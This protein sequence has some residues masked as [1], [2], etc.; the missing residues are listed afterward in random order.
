M[1][2]VALTLAALDEL[3]DALAVHQ[4]VRCA[5]LFGKDGLRQSLSREGAV[6]VALSGALP[7]DLNPGADVGVDVLV[8]GRN[9]NR[10]A[11]DAIERF[12]DALGPNAHVTFHLSLE[13][14]LMRELGG[15]IKPMLEKLGMSRDEPIA[16][17]MV[18]RA[19][20]NAQE[21]RSA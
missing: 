6:A 21:K 10:A 14:K 13:D 8:C 12:A 17:S 9:D 7:L 4:P 5:D 2:V 18:T 1:V 15:S 11:D 16:H 19:I 20:K 3:G